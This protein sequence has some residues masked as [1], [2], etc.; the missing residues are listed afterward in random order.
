MENGAHKDNYKVDSPSCFSREWGG[1]KWVFPTI[2]LM[3][4]F[5][6]SQQLMKRGFCSRFWGMGR[7]FHVHSNVE[8]WSETGYADSTHV[9]KNLKRKAIGWSTHRWSSQA[10]HTQAVISALY[11]TAGLQ[12][13]GAKIASPDPAFTAVRNSLCTPSSDKIQTEQK[14]PALVKWVTGLFNPGGFPCMHPDWSGLMALNGE[15]LE[16]EN[17]QPSA[18]WLALGF[19][20]SRVC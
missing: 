2:P 9:L 4:T 3:P 20:V 6:C 16:K 7:L 10:A 13:K 8:R 17:C 5:C 14:G 11:V 18:V 19:A 12:Q 1:T 15:R